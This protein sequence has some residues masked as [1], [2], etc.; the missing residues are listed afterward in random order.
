MA[1]TKQSKKPKQSTLRKWLIAIPVV[2]VVALLI[3]TQTF[4]GGNI[5]FYSEWARC[6]QK[7]V[8]EGGMYMTPVTHYKDPPMFA[9]FRDEWRTNYYCT[10]IEA[11]RKGISADPRIYDFPEMRRAGEKHP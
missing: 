3:D 8:V 6:G 1:H 5:H 11:E 7:P 4:V 9:L 2:I 10:A